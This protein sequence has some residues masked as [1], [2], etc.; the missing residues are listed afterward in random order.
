MLD[1]MTFWFLLHVC[2]IYVCDI[3]SLCTSKANVFFF[4]SIKSF[5]CEL[6]EPISFMAVIAEYSDWFFTRPL[7]LYFFFLYFRSGFLL[8]N[9]S[10]LI[11]LLLQYVLLISALPFVF[12]INIFNCMRAYI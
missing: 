11:G 3:V 2:T 10:M 7:F 12:T 5:L 1:I 8:H 6:P 4:L 9:Q